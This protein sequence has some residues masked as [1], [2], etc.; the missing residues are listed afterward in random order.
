MGCLA[1]LHN[2]GYVHY[3][4]YFD[5]ERWTDLI[6]DFKREMQNLYALSVDSSLEI[7]L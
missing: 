2:P 5:N 6:Q 4:Y 1:F 3:K 7:N